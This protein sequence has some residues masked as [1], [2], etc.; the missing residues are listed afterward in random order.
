MHPFNDVSYDQPLFEGTQR[1]YMI[2]TTPRVGSTLL[3]SLLHSTGHMGVPH[4]YFH[5]DGVTQPL[6]QRWGL[7]ERTTTKDYIAFIQK[8]RST[9][10]GVFGLKAHFNQIEKPIKQTSLMDFLKTVDHFIYLTRDDLMEQAISYAKAHQTQN[11][12]SLQEAEAEPTYDHQLITRALNDILTQNARWL[13]FF[14]LY[15]IKPLRITY[16]ELLDQP[17]TVCRRICR[18]MGYLPD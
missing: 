7:S 6:M 5:I 15:D 12:L 8:H 11:W 4:E 1:S 14:A 3:G 9:P 18:T 2:C 10:N 17:D 13:K 16:E